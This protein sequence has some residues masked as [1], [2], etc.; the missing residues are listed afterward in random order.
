MH[1]YSPPYYS[2]PLYSPLLSPPS[3]FPNIA[4]GTLLR[5]YSLGSPLNILPFFH[6]MK[7]YF[8]VK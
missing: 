2:H 1:L 3:K 7:V 4:L 8:L 5:Y 6:G